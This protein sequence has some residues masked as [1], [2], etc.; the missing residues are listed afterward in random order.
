MR[1][2]LVDPVERSIALP[3]GAW[4]L[5]VAPIGGWYHTADRVLE[6]LVG[7]SSAS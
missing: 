1:K 2:A 7:C 5:S 6:G 3:N 4:T